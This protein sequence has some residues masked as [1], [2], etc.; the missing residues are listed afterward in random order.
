MSDGADIQF[1]DNYL[2]PIEADDYTISVVQT[3]SSADSAHPLN[4]QF[5]ATQDFT[6]VAP[7]FALPP[8]DVQSVFPPGNAT[9]I[10]A[11]NLPHVVLTERTLPWER[12]I[13]EGAPGTSGTPWMALLLFTPDEI[14]P[15]GGTP[16][17]SALT[18]PTLVGTY[19][20]SPPAGGGDSLLKPLDA[21]TLGPNL[22][23]GAVNETTCQAIDIGTDT[24]ARVVPLLAELPFLAHV[25]DVTGA[26]A[27]KAT[28]QALAGGWFSVVLGNRFPAAPAGTSLTPTSG[29]RNIAHLVSLEGFD[30]YLVDNPAWPPGITKVRLAS[31]LSWS[32]TCLAE[33]GDF[34][35]LMQN[36]VA[37]PV[38]S[39]TLTNPGSGYVSAPTVGFGG[40]GSGATA[41]ATVAVAGA[42]G[43]LTL[44]S[45][46]SGYTT[47]PAVVFSGGGGMGAVA[48][49]T[50]SSN[51]S[52]CGV[53]LTAAGTDYTSAPLLTFEGGGGAGATATAALATAGTVNVTLLSGGLGYSS[54]PTVTFEGG[55]GSGA[56]AQAVLAIQGGDALRLRLPVAGAA[57]QPGTAAAYAQAALRSG[58]AALGYDTRVGD[59]TFGWYHGP[60]VPDPIASFSE[61]QAFTSAAAATIYDPTTGTFDLSYAAGWEVGRMLA[62]ADRAYS[63]NKMGLQKALRKK[64][65]LLRERGR[66]GI[67][68]PSS[69]ADAT[70][71]PSALGQQRV[72]RALLRWMGGGLDGRLPRP[73]VKAGVPTRKRDPLA[74]DTETLST[75]AALRDFHAQAHVQAALNQHLTDH[76][77]EAPVSSVVGWL[78]NLRL[79]QG[80]PFAHLVPDARMLPP[81]SVRFFYVD[82]NYLDALCDG[83]GSVGVQTTR[84][85][86]QHGAVRGTL[87][88]A[89]IRH[90]HGL[91]ARRLRAVAPPAGGSA[92][93]PVA[94]FLLRSAVVS[95]W[96]GMEVKAYGAIV[97]G[98]NP[99][100]PDPDTLIAPVRMDRL[101]PDVLICLYPQ[102]PAWI[103]FD[104]PKETL[105]FGVEDPATAG[106]PP[107]VALRYLAGANIGLT[108]GTNVQ[109]TA[110]YLRDATN[111]VLNVAAWQG[112]L[113]TQVSAETPPPTTAWGPG[114]FAIQMVRAPEQMIFQ[115]QLNPVPATAAAHV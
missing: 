89:A 105:A 23:A 91:R 72:S 84:D 39:L 45:G 28:D 77:A 76:L 43:D 2:P 87:R 92:S 69:A 81:E 115:T 16:P 25:R 110:A 58:Y 71:P 42:L 106:G 56:S 33:V 24:F 6:V 93:D 68:H 34:A 67:L 94:G 20:V 8:A 60:L 53:S 41:V 112:Y 109:L 86:A 49:A 55:G 19:P 102:V 37:G 114:A 27:H 44:A 4:E 108:T 38:G 35:S 59:Q 111:R 61:A 75:A 82:P 64:V 98:S 96:P 73:G 36:L 54:P 29:V 10:F 88:R 12:L 104:E 30:A 9:G 40:G 21:A 13:R 66:A 22:V 18:N 99:L 74:A 90:A 1:F 51:G 79:L 83:A 26:L 48:T 78:A 14:V 70:E 103:E 62:L 46:G 31:L 17:A 5:A 47:A 101:A 113:D 11:Q 97:T 100:R 3:V 57:Q 15:P 7:R 50:L 80:V 32:F 95:G 52:V 65:N 85:A 107:Q 63:T